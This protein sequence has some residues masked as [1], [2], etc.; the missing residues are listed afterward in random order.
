M[1]KLLL[2][3][4]FCYS[5]IIVSQKF[6]DVRLVN[7]NFGWGED[8]WTP[9]FSKLSNDD[10]LNLILLNNN[11]IRYQPKIAHPYQPYSNKMMEIQCDCDVNKLVNDLNTYSSVVEKAVISDYGIFKDALTI[12]IL[13]KEIG[14]PTGV[15]N[16][17]ITTND[18][19]L[20]QIFKDFNVFYYD[21]WCTTCGSI[22]SLAKAYSIVCDCDN[23]ALKIALD[24]YT[25]V[26][27][28]TEYA[29]GYYYLNNKSFEQSNPTISPN[30]F[31]STF[32]INT[33]ENISNYSIFDISGKQIINCKS[34]T[35]LDNQ[36]L[37]LTRGIYILNLESESKKVFSQKLIK[38]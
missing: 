14:I 20:N 6:V 34:K 26:I 18:D 22:P 21:H 15:N 32:T 33:K 16:S 38:Q 11:V 37:N 25:S 4:V 29:G 23:T 3:F 28:I 5:Q 7:E 13:N 19:G 8:S 17:I 24:N 30:P 9:D 36:S 31:T 2:L 27:E 35:E 1:K 12:G 10:G